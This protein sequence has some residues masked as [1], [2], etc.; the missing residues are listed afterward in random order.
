MLLRP[1]KSK[2][3]HGYLLAGVLTLVMIIAMIISL[4]I[5][6][7]HHYLL[8]QEVLRERVEAQMVIQGQVSSLLSKL[9]RLLETNG[10]LNAS[11]LAQNAVR[12]S[13]DWFACTSME[14]EAVDLSLPAVLTWSWQSRPKDPLFP[15]LMMGS[16]NINVTLRVQQ[17]HTG[18]QY[19]GDIQL[20]VRVLS[21]AEFAL[22]DPGENHAQW[23]LYHPNNNTTRVYVGKNNGDLQFMNHAGR[24]LDAYALKNRPNLRLFRPRPVPGKLAGTTS[25]AANNLMDAAWRPWLN[26]LLPALEQWGN[27]RWQTEVQANGLAD[28]EDALTQMNITALPQAVYQWVIPQQGPL[29]LPELPALPVL[30]LQQVM[31]QYMGTT[32]RFACPRTNQIP[33]PFIV[34][35]NATE[36]PRNV[37]LVFPPDVFVF[38]DGDVNAQNTKRLQISGQIG[39]L[40]KTLD[41]LLSMTNTINYYAL[42]QQ[43]FVSD[44]VTVS[45]QFQPPSPNPLKVD[46]LTWTFEK[47][48][49]A[50]ARLLSELAQWAYQVQDFYLTNYSPNTINRPGIYR[51]RLKLLAPHE[52]CYIQGSRLMDYSTNLTWIVETNRTRTYNAYFS[53]PDICSVTRNYAL[54]ACDDPHLMN[55]TFINNNNLINTDLQITCATQ[56]LQRPFLDNSIRYYHLNLPE[57]ARQTTAQAYLYQWQ[58]LNKTST[59]ILQALVPGGNYAQSYWIAVAWIEVLPPEEGGYYPETYQEIRDV[60]KIT[61]DLQ[62]WQTLQ[63]EPLPVLDDRYNDK[64]WRTLLEEYTQVPGIQLRDRYLDGYY[65]YGVWKIQ[66]ISTYHRKQRKIQ[67]YMLTE[68]DLQASLVKTAFYQRRVRFH[69]HTLGWIPREVIYP[70]TRV[71]FGRLIGNN[72]THQFHHLQLQQVHIRGQATFE[73][74]PIQEKAHITRT[75]SYVLSYEPEWLPE[76]NM[77]RFYDVRVVK[78]A[79]R[80]YDP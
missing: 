38:F 33:V 14:V 73:R 24:L 67:T 5:T 75:G 68:D 64:P 18:V 15:N 56:Q 25:V 34:I 21:P 8:H 19:Q 50:Y 26:T 47:P 48:A 63:D 45:R 54:F 9:D 3:D 61:D 1:S 42:D 29:Q 65:A 31:E 32:L 66:N 57:L 52:T 72:G 28:Y 10:M 46:P 16:T 62:F 60:W 20:Q 30:N 80:K 23:M 77:D 59:E 53:E 13:N 49:Q 76:D 44:I 39:F 41:E 51:D 37:Q 58:P 78:H 43:H 74:N 12:V 35:T 7:I 22:F 70:D 71:F 2:T 11:S 55:V 79:F 27:R 6:T 40:P 4:A 36:I 17:P 69:Y